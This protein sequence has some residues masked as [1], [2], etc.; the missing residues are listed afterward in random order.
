M[1]EIYSITLS[2]AGICQ[3]AYLVQ[4]LA[5]S[6]KCDHNAFQ[7]CLE[8]V[9]EIKPKSLITIYGNN[10]KN[11]HLGLKTLIS[12]LK[13]SNFSYLYVEL[14]KYILD[15]IFIENK[16]KKNREH[17]DLIKK[18]LENICNEYHQNNNFSTLI[19][20]IANVYIHKISSLGSQVL[21]KGT[22]SFLEDIEIQ[23]KIRCLLF[24]GIRS[25]VLWRQ[26][27]GNRLKL[28]F[29]RYHIIQKAKKILFDLKN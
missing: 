10:E 23:K 7:I 11:L 4:Q 19:N 16:L 24:S 15:M 20:K 8:S 17:I 21:V 2:F 22:K 14:M 3:S 28:I 26:F 27:G 13:F 5:Y 25:I 1:K 12:I 18:S 9:L 6:G 29:F